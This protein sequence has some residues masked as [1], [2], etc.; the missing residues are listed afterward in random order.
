M[1]EKKCPKKF[2]NV[3]TILGCSDKMSEANFSPDETLK[4][5]PSRQNILYL[6]IMH[7]SV[8]YSYHKG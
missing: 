7:T 3:R 8:I 1:S 6:G 4:T 5:T 2:P